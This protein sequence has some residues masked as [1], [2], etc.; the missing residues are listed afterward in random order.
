[1]PCRPSVWAGPLFSLVLAISGC[2]STQEP[3]PEIPTAEPETSVSAKPKR[4][5]PK[6]EALSENCLA[7]ADTQ[8]KVPGSEAVMI[9]PVGW[10][11]AQ[12]SDYTISKIEGSAAAIVLAGFDATGAEEPKAREATYTKLVT[13]LEITL[14]EKFK[15]KFMPK[16]EKP[17]DVRKNGNME[18]KLWQAEAAKREGKTGYLLVLM[19]V[20]P[21]GKKI[22]GVAFSPEGDEDSIK[23][24]SAALETIG[25]GSYQ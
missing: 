21:A 24:I 3:D 12:Q 25:P 16:W 8:A 5:K 19:T 18:L 10:G 7:T 14:P 22:V 17:D 11:Y 13:A 20:D 9:P 23:K 4:Q 2:G 1:M 6:C 15:K